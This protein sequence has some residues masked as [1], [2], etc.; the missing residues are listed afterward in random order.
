VR[1]ARDWSHG[2]LMGAA[3]GSETT[4][5]ATGAVGVLR[6]DSMAMKPF[7][8]Y[9]YGDYFQHWLSFDRPGAKLPKIFHVNWFRKGADGKFLWPG[10]GENLR[11][12]E[13]MIN[14]VEGRVGGM[15]TPIGILP[16]ADGLKLDGL[17]LDRARLDELLAVDNAGW[18]TELEAIGEYLESFEPRLPER[19]RQEQ[20]RVAQ[21]LRDEVSHASRR[22]TAA[23]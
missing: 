5:A 15:E 2:V 16:T 11:V 22:A 20:Q 4:A 3:M 8:G 6:R 21:A 1:E 23:S 10:F 12:L 13:W 19:L 7:C 17:K 18:Q 14:R 9:H